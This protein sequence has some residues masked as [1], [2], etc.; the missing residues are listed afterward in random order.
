MVLSDSEPTNLHIAQ[1]VRVHDLL[2]FPEESSGFG[3]RGFFPAS[4]KMWQTFVQSCY[5]NVVQS[6]RLG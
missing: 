4:V 5:N 6:D 1:Y 3:R 2:Q